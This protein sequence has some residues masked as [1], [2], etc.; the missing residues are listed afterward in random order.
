MAGNSLT[1]I[2]FN[3]LKGNKKEVI[4]NKLWQIVCDEMGYTEALAKRKIAAF[5]NAL[6][7]DARFIS[8]EQNHW[9]L[10]ERHAED[11][12]QIDPDLL[13]DDEDI[14]YDDF[15]DEE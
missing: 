7:L 3:Y 8:L 6:M 2:A 9:D 10:R 15:L 4:F 11:T 1:D 13:P 5:Y 14:E 12:L